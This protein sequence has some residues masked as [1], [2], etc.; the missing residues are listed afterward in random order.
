[1]KYTGR[2]GQNGVKQIQTG[3]ASSEGLSL[4]QI[5]TISCVLL[6]VFTCSNVRLE[7]YQIFPVGLNW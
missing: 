3:N 7:L 5:T 6:I 2:G 1:M 4:L